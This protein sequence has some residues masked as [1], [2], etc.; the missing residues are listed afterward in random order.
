MRKPVLVLGCGNPL[1]GDDGFGPEV[2]ERL[3]GEFRH[4]LPEHVCVL[5]AGTGFR[6]VLFNLVLSEQR[7][8]RLIVVDAIDVGR[9][10]GEVFT[11]SVD[12]LP[13]VEIEDFSMHQLPT[14]S[15]LRELQNLCGVEV[16]VLSCQVGRV[17][18][19]VSPGLSER[20]REAVGEA[21]E[22]IIEMVEM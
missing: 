11:I 17:P 7:P 12:Q 5:N 21:C 13:E 22:K 18:E 10:P 15:L 8:R 9:T 3:A 19:S 2:A 20:V 16:V 6:E 4:Q 14:S 1:F